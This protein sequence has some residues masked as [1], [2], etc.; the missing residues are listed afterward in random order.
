VKDLV[1]DVPQVSAKSFCGIEQMTTRAEPVEALAGT[2]DEALC[3]L[4]RSQTKGERQG[5]K[6][7]PSMTYI[8]KGM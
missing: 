6:G 8:H 5:R 7:K 3:Q 1:E 4:Q 2:P